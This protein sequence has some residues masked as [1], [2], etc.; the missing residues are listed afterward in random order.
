LVIFQ[1][2]S[3]AAVFLA[4]LTLKTEENIFFKYTFSNKH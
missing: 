4:C 3:R 2:R 1:T